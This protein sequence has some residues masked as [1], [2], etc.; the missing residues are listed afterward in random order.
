MPQ[1]GGARKVRW[2]GRGRGKSVGV[3]VITF[4]SGPPVP[5]FLLTVFGKGEKVNLG[6]AEMN[7]LCKLL[8]TLVAAY[9][10]GGKRHVQGR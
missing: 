6:R 4:F 2:G 8:G 5:V 3:R 1:S 7:A 10:K 9:R